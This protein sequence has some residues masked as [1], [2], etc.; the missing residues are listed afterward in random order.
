MNKTKLI[1]EWMK[2]GRSISS[3]VAFERF[4]ATRLSSVIFKLR[5]KGYNIDT[6]MV[7][8]KDRYGNAVRY[9]NYW[10]MLDDNG[11]IW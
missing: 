9:A 7:Q 4:G 6:E 10:L 5:K 8:A 11:D 1:L 2:S 3:Q